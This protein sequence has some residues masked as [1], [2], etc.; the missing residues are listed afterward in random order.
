M[1][2]L[3]EVAEN[4]LIYDLLSADDE[5]S[6]GNILKEGATTCFEARGNDQGME[7]QGYSTFSESTASGGSAA[8]SQSNAIGQYL[9]FNVN[10]PSV[11]VYAYRQALKG[12]PTS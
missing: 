4:E 11:G 2:A 7:H 3:A 12:L 6:W 9:T 5:H 10:V 8:S 1:K